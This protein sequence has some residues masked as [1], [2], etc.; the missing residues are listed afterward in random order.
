MKRTRDE[1]KEPNTET[2]K[3]AKT[4]TQAQFNSLFKRQTEFPRSR[5]AM[6]IGD[7]GCMLVG[8]GVAKEGFSVKDLT[9]F[10]KIFHCEPI[11]LHLALP[12]KEQRR[13]EHEAAVLLIKNGVNKLMSHSE[14]KTDSH[15]QPQAASFADRLLKEQRRL[16]YDRFR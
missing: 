16:N 11:L 14:A 3:K 6:T 2:S 5:Y 8:N 9:D 7:P 13:P 4:L 10:G 15:G 12:S 1:S